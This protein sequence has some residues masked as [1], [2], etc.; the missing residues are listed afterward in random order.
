MNILKKVSWINQTH[1]FKVSN[2]LQS[3]VERKDDGEII[4][5]GKSFLPQY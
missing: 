5:K 3:V 2:R 1:F 4:P